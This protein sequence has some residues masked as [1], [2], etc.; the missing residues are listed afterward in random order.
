MIY[1]HL[2]WKLGEDYEYMLH[3][4]LSAK[5]KSCIPIN[6]SLLAPTF[7]KWNIDCISLRTILDL[8]KIFVDM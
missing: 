3:N 4:L 5:T 2:K 1:N 8:K 7:G 6:E